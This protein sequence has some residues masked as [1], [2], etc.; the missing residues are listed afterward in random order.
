[1][2]GVT[3]FFVSFEK[4]FYDISVDKHRSDKKMQRGLWQDQAWDGG[5]H[6][7]I[8][9]GDSRRPLGSVDRELG[10]T[11]RAG[12]A[13]GRHSPTR[14]HRHIR[15]WP[16]ARGLWRPKPVRSPRPNGSM[17]MWG[18]KVSCRA[19]TVRAGGL[20]PG[21]GVAGRCGAPI[22]SRP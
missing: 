16:F 13:G 12:A 3:A 4:R 8:R 6:V 17:Q 2:L 10:E 9:I 21:A 15:A 18:A 7:P 5:G 11:G 20:R 19:E 14:T 22:Y 1:M